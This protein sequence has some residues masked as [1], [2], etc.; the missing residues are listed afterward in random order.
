MPSGSITASIQATG[1]ARTCWPGG[2]SSS[3][4]SRSASGATNLDPITRIGCAA[5]TADTATP[6]SSTRSWSESG[7]GSGIYGAPSTRT[8]KS[9]TCCSRSDETQHPPGASSGATIRRRARRCHEPLQPGPP[10]GRSGS[11]PDA[12]SRR[13][14]VMGP[15]CGDLTA[16]QQRETAAAQSKFGNTETREPW[17]TCDWS[18]EPPG[19]DPWIA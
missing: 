16:I 15:G 6:S 11:L 5:G 10:L 18:G 19:R 7:V 9:S 3:P 17:T 2:A 12:A 1:T 14:C 8:M 13:L 4:T